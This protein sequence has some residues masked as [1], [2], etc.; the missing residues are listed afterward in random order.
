MGKL[1]LS[2]YELACKR[3]V[4]S[5][6]GEQFQKNKH[7]DNEESDFLPEFIDSWEKEIYELNQLYY[8]IYLMINKLGFQIEHDF[9]N[10][11]NKNPYLQIDPD[12]IGTLAFNI[13]DSFETFM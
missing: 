7:L 1:L 2:A 10:V 12:D 3:I 13:G 11:K 6:Y 5:N 8:F 9:L 4:T